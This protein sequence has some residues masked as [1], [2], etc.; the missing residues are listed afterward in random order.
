MD[1]YNASNVIQETHE[2][3]EP[4]AMTLEE[5]EE[6]KAA[7]ERAIEGHSA[8][9]RLAENEDFKALVM[10]GY[11]SEHPKRLGAMI[12]SGRMN[13]K[14][15]EGAVKDLEGVASFRTYL[16]QHLEQGQIARDEL[17]ALEEAFQ[18]AMENEAAE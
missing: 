11:F 7:M 15:I 8:A 16:Q 3:D 1:L 17:A 13:S 6:N 9:L 5:Y 10:E 12:A 2:D 14:N 4:V 18:E